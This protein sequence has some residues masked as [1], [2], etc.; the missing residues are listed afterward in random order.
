MLKTSADVDTSKTERT[1]VQP[2]TSPVLET[3][4]LFRDFPGKF[5]GMTAVVK[6][7][8]NNG[9]LYVFVYMWQTSVHNG[10]SS[11]PIVLNRMQMT[12]LLLLRNKISLW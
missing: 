8:E 1:C 9:C 3:T 11:R 2:F 12:L 6:F 4:R 7:T 5:E 10:L